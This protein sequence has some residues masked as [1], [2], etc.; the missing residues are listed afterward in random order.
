MGQRMVTL[1]RAATDLPPVYIPLQA[2]P[3]TA[4]QFPFFTCLSYHRQSV[5][6]NPFRSTKSFLC[7][8]KY[9]V[10]E[11]PNLC[12]S[13]GNAN[14]VSFRDPLSAQSFVD[15]CWVESAPVPKTKLIACLPPDEELTRLGIRGTSRTTISRIYLQSVV[16]RMLGQM[17]TRLNAGYD[18]SPFSLHLQG[19]STLSFSED[20]GIHDYPGV[21]SLSLQECSF[22]D[23]SSVQSFLEAFPIVRKF[24]VRNIRWPFCVTGS[25]AELQKLELYLPHTWID[26]LSEVHIRV[27]SFGDLWLLRQ[28]TLL[29][30]DNLEKLTVEWDDHY[31]KKYFKDHLRKYVDISNFPK[32]HTLIIRGLPTDPSRPGPKSMNA[33]DGGSVL[34]AATGLLP[35][36]VPQNLVQRKAPNVNGLRNREP[37]QYK[38]WLNRVAIDLGHMSESH[39]SPAL[40]AEFNELIKKIRAL[41]FGQPGGNYTNGIR[42]FVGLVPGIITVYNPSDPAGYGAASGSAPSEAAELQASEQETRQSRCRYLLEDWLAGTGVD[43]SIEEID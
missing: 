25:A 19:F 23:L 12:L 16:C 8:C 7:T 31:Q 32:L 38:N 21:S 40:W 37:E 5:V 26:L 13:P 14:V 17:H 22:N 29:A 15:T 20:D 28:L 42:A 39:P 4:S 43:V 41:R 1:R 6:D 36:L 27:A 34:T 9:F 30:P 18:N 10:M 33:S 3:W 2:T 35:C 11:I 24:E